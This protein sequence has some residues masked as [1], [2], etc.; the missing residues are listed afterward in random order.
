MERDLLI[1]TGIV[2]HDFVLA[3]LTDFIAYCNVFFLSNKDITPSGLPGAI[4]MNIRNPK[5]VTP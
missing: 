3:Y 2:F 1:S 5:G 4:I